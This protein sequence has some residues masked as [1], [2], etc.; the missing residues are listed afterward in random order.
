MID[1]ACFYSLFLGNSKT[2]Q[3][4]P[5]PLLSILTCPFN[6]SIA[7]FTIAKPIPVRSNAEVIFWTL[8]NKY[9]IF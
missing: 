9:N 6:L 2:K 3:L 8:L 7:S 1:F 4:P 5:F